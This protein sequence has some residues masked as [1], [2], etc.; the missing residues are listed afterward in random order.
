MITSARLAVYSS[1]R[2]FFLFLFYKNFVLF[3]PPSIVTLSVHLFLL[4]LPVP[5]APFPLSFVSLCLPTYHWPHNFLCQSYKSPTLHSFP[6][7]YSPRPSSSLWVFIAL[8]DLAAEQKQSKTDSLSVFSL[9]LQH[10]TAFWILLLLAPHIRFK[11]T[12]SFALASAPRSHRVCFWLC[13][14]NKKVIS[15]FTKS[16]FHPN[17]ITIIIII[18]W[19]FK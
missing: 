5:P 18:R 7:S 3:P 15:Y 13:M 9:I 6:L 4:S 10:E 14:Q 2:F 11:S 19:I 8:H 1:S 17:C 16:F 12:H